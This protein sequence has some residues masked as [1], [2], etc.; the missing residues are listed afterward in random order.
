MIAD[1]A[2]IVVDFQ[3]DFAKPEFALGEPHMQDALD[4]TGRFLDRYR[5]SGRTPI[6]IRTTHNDDVDAPTWL[7]KYADQDRERP[8]LSGTAGAEFVPELDAQ[9][10]DVVVTK[11][12][13]DAFFNTD[14]DTYFRA[15]DISEVL[16]CGVATN[17]C[18]EATVR[19]AFNR[20]YDVRVLA[21]CCTTGQTDYEDR[22]L[23]NMDQFLGN[24][25]ESTEVEL[26]PVSPEAIA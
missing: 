2:L 1:P 7:E 9:D 14:L 15:N 12:R 8:C 13:Y 18:V 11:H 19:G 26:P 5:A 20:D 25:V 24:V 22:C 10:S 3:N 21:D 4:A 17:V 6:L 23:E 16:V